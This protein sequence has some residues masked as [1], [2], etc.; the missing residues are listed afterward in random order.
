[1]LT[2]P[3]AGPG[4]RSGCSGADR[5][6]LQTSRA[7]AI[8]YATVTKPADRC[9]GSGGRRGSSPA[10]APA[11][12]PGRPG[13]AAGPGCS[14]PRLRCQAPA[15]SRDDQAERRGQAPQPSRSASALRMSRREMLGERQVAAPLVAQRA[16]H[17][18]L[19]LAHRRF[20]PGQGVGIQ[21]AGLWLSGKPQR[22]AHCQFGHETLVLAFALFAVAA[23]HP[24][25]HRAMRRRCGR[26]AGP[27]GHASTVR[28]RFLRLAPRGDQRERPLRRPRSTVR[29]R[30]GRWRAEPPAA[31]HAGRRRRARAAGRGLVPSAHRHGGRRRRSTSAA[32]PPWPRAP[33]PAG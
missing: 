30:R 28:Q 9:R 21:L 25:Q 2:S 17:R 23:S 20:Q 5:F 1:M 6:S 10:A 18:A 4:Q 19:R 14:A 12:R 7:T 31:S 26:Q 24:G 3:S 27:C 33:P 29:I 32:S 15:S 8:G 13:H 16:A 22:L 11:A